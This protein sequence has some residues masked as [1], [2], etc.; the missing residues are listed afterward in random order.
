MQVTDNLRGLWAADGEDQA[1][2][3]GG[4]QD[5]GDGQELVQAQELGPGQ[6]LVHMELQLRK[7]SELQTTVDSANLAAITAIL[8]KDN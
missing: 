2:H 6:G 5:T 3:Q 1:G 4:R 8:F 7:S